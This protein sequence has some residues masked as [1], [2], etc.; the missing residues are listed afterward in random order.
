MS[1]VHS[2]LRGFGIRSQ[3]HLMRP[4]QDQSACFRG[5]KNVLDKMLDRRE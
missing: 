1:F 3:K 5:S 4:S 2:A